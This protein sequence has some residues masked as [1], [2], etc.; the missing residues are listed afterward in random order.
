MDPEENKLEEA[1]GGIT[2][3]E[4]RLLEKLKMLKIKPKMDTAKDMF[5]LVE[6]FGN[7]K[8]ETTHAPTVVDAHLIHDRPGHFQFLKYPH[9]L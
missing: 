2:E 3:D 1:A 5:K 9:S 8:P 4:M 7:V 6:A